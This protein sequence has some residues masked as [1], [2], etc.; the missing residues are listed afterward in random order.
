MHH[1]CVASAKG[2]RSSGGVVAD[3]TKLVVGRVDDDIRELTDGHEADLSGHDTSR[4]CWCGHHATALGLQGEASVKGLRRRLEGSRP[5]TGSNVRGM[6]AVRARQLRRALTDG[7]GAGAGLES[8]NLLQV[9][10]R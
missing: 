9:G 2:G 5:A 3:V 8:P 10:R 4:G 6:T 7:V 1:G